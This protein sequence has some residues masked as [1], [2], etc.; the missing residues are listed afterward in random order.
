MKPAILLNGWIIP[1]AFFSV[2]IVIVEHASHRQDHLTSPAKLHLIL[3]NPDYQHIRH[4]LQHVVQHLFATINSP[5][6]AYKHILSLT[7]GH[8]SCMVEFI[9]VISW[10]INQRLFS[11][12]HI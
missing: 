1:T 9:T 2:S 8:I 10:N 11:R 3:S 12:N 4:S 5:F 6:M 7:I